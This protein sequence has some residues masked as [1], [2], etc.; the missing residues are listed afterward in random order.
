M[1]TGIVEEMGTVVTLVRAGAVLRLGVQAGATLEGSDVGAS[2]AV[3]GAC[4]TVVER[5]PDGFV[6]ELGPET[7]ARTTL[8]R[9]KPGDPVNLERP[10]R[11][12]GALGGHL[13]LGHVDG[14]GTVEDVT[15]VEST[16]RVR[17]ALPGRELEPLL[18]PQGS[19]AVDGVSLTV[20]ALGDRSFEVMLIPYTL[21]ATTLGRLRPGQATNVEADVIGKYLVRSLA[22]RGAI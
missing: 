7:L 19:V 12:G 11:F 14:V 1:F 21:A 8:G 4:L 9:L 2:V 10:L 5:P 22:L 18:I 17:V 16:T 15:R 3:N 20:A 13:V 6:F